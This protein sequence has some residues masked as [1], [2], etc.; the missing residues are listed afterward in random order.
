MKLT[1]PKEITFFIAVILAI[2]G[3]LASQGVIHTGYAFAMVL[4]GFIVLALGNLVK[5]L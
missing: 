4:I 5:G 1:P 2:L 3:A